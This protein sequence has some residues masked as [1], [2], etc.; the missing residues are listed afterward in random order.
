M[1]AGHLDPGDVWDLEDEE[2]L[3]AVRLLLDQYAPSE[4]ENG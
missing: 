4:T 2:T 3:A 1:T